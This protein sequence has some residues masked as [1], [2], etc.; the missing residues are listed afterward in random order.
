MQTIENAEF[1]HFLQNI[2]KKL[3]I[4]NNKAHFL[5]SGRNFLLILFGNALSL[6]IEKNVSGNFFGQR[7]YQ[8][9]IEEVA[10]FFSHP[11]VFALISG[12]TCPCTR[13]KRL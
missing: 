4:I 12:V 13:R 1:L 10:S 9:S 6:G 3:L 2:S 7:F 11:R 8:S 5:K